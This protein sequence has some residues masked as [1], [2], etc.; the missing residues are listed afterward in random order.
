MLTPPDFSHHPDVQIGDL[1]CHRL[2]EALTD[3]QLWV[4]KGAEEQWESVWIG[5]RRADGQVLIVSPKKREPS[6]V[7]EDWAQ[8]KLKDL[9]IH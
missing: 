4:W 3:V 2:S 5:Y 1:F 6:W 9:G 7:G 8:K